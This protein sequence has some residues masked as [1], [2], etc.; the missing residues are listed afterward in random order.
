MEQGEGRS[1]PPFPDAIFHIGAKSFSLLVQLSLGWRDLGHG[2]QTEQAAQ[3][4]WKT[5]NQFEMNLK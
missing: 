4:S 1:A 2:L 5:L 3:I